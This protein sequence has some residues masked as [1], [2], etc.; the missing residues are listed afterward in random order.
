M[1]SYLFRWYLLLFTLLLPLVAQ[2]QLNAVF[3]EV[4]SA[5]LRQQPKHWAPGSVELPYGTALSELSREAGWLRVRT[6]AG[7]EGF[8]HES[9]ITSRK[10]VLSAA[11][12]GAN[13][14]PDD[15]DVVLAGK[16]FSKELEGGLAGSRKDLNFT[17]VDALQKNHISDGELFKFIKLGKLN[18]GGGLARNSGEAPN[19]G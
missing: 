2:S 3:V 5:K 11:G 9:A 6:G 16:G 19:R 14:R 10:I 12:A 7:Q 17:Q 1:L 15:S 13:V 8:V 4:S 18:E